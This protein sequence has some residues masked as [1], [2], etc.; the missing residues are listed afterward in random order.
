[1]MKRWERKQLSKASNDDGTTEKNAKNKVEIMWRMENR[2][3]SQ[4]K[5]TKD[6]R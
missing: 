5:G 2:K 3:C 4:V 1:M 6:K